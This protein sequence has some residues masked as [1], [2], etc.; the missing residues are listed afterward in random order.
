MKGLTLR[1]RLLLPG[2]AALVLLAAFGV[3]DGGAA[4]GLPHRGRARAGQPL[5]ALVGGQDGAEIENGPDSIGACLTTALHHPRFGGSKRFP[6]S[7]VSS[8][9]YPVNRLFTNAEL[10]FGKSF[11]HRAAQAGGRLD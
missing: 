5:L 2:K 6:H 7:S 10:R 8:A 4:A 9:P 1:L 3:P 11:G